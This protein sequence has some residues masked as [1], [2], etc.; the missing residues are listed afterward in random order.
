MSKESM[1]LKYIGISSGDVNGIGPEIIL[2]SI[3]FLQKQSYYKPIIFAHPSLLSEYAKKINWSLPTE[4]IEIA[5]PSE[6]QPGKINCI[7][8]SGEPPE[9]ELGKITAISGEYAMQ[10][11]KA[12]TES[13][14]NGYTHAL[15]TAPISKEA[16]FKA[17]YEDPGHTEY[18]ARICNCNAQPLMV[19]ATEY[20]RVALV[21]IHVPISK[22]SQYITFEHVEKTAMDFYDALK[23]DFGILKPKLAVLGLNP[24]A[25]DGGVLGTEEMEVIQPV[26]N[27]L[28]KN[29]YFVDG[30]FAADGFFGNKQ[31]EQYDGILAMYHDQGLAPFKT[32]AFH[33]GVNVTCNLPIVRTSP[34]HGTGFSIAGKNLA[35]TSSFIEAYKT[36]QTIISNRGIYT[37]TILTAT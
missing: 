7:V 12:A 25:G 37:K 22:I 14:L 16:I 33:S 2:K 21:S 32:I 26:I 29:N 15:V 8:P 27:K 36:A 35:E 19:L 23:K 34:D 17:G 31:W 13:I 5:Q 6:W 18:L 1:T 3:L 9:I 11:V 4:C 10:S 24:H 30:P 28:K 20:L